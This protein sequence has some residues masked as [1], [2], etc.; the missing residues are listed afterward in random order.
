MQSTPGHSATGKPVYHPHRHL[1]PTLFPVIFRL[2]AA[3]AE[4]VAV[5]GNFAGGQPS[6]MR[7]TADDYWQVT[8]DLKRGRYEYR[9][10]VDDAPVLDPKSRGI[11]TG[12]D[13]QKYSLL[14]VGF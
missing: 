14:E 3:H 2:H 11:L 8:V 4:R 1:A 13:G 6:P 9:F 12:A 10:V 5:V 7:R